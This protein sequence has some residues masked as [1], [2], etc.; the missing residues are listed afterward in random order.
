MSNRIN[1][2]FR[3]LRP[4]QWYKNLLVL[5]ALIFTWGFID[6]DSNIRILIGFVALT[7]ASSFNYVLNDII[8]AKKDRNHPE[9]RKRPIVS[10]KVS[11][12]EAIVLALLLLIIGFIL[13]YYL[14]TKFFIT[15]LIFI[16]LST[17]YSLGLKNIAI[18]DVLLISINFVLRSISGAYI[19]DVVISPWLV[20]CTFLTAMFLSLG[21]RRG[22]QRFLG[23]DAKNH[24][25][26]FK[27]YTKKILMTMIYTIAFLLLLSYTLYTI[28]A[29]KILLV[30][31]VP[32]A[33]YFLFRFI[34][35]IKKGDSIARSAHLF[36]KDIKMLLVLLIWGLIVFLV[37]Y[38][39]V[40]IG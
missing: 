6:L 29:G 25:A 28:F 5:L 30:F 14:S 1:Q 31:T 36:I 3:L 35:H 21:K 33:S 2:L 32:F 26:V 24:K 19:I 8:D 37:E 39:Y 34:F 17:V 23:K 11:R 18:L 20:I 40:Y 15:L 27:F 38:Y 7:F 4:W 16:I 22:D 13:A 9:K 12:F 10:G